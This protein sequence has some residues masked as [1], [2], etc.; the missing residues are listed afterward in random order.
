M[1]SLKNMTQKNFFII[2]VLLCSLSN[3]FNILTVSAAV[4]TLNSIKINEQLPPAGAIRLTV[5]GTYSDNTSS[6][7][8]SG[9]VWESSDINIAIVDS[10]GNVAFTGRAGAVTISATY[11][12]KNNSVSVTTQ[13]APALSAYIT[14]NGL[15]HSCERGV[16]YNLTI[17]AVYS[18]NS[19]EVM[20]NKY[21]TFTSSDTRIAVVNAEGTVSVHGEAG[22][23]MITAKYRDKT[24]VVISLIN[25]TGLV[26]TQ[27]IQEGVLSGI[28]ISGDMPKEPFQTRKLEVKGEYTDGYSRPLSIDAIWTTSNRE[29]VNITNDGIISFGGKYGEVTITARY[30]QYMDSVKIYIDNS[31]QVY[32]EVR[33]M[34]AAEALVHDRQKSY[35]DESV[36]DAGNIV[37]TLEKLVAAYQG[38]NIQAFKDIKN[39]WSEKEINIASELGII[40]GYSDNTFKP[41]ERISRAEFAAVIYKAFSVRYYIDDPDKTF[42]DVKGLWYQDYVMALKNSNIINGYADGTFKPNSYITRGEMIAIISRLIVKEDI[43]QKDSTEK[44]KDFNDSFW[45]KGDI[46]KLYSIGALEMI[47]KS[48][49]EPNKSAT[50]AEVVNII[51]RLLMNI[52]KNSK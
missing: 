25:S 45:A 10:N 22:A 39:H 46:D 49:L 4:P 42:K 5:T 43:T 37:T 16:V 19:V 32:E 13:Y 3:S 52:D 29:I 35:F 8:G 26:P 31:Q 50:R 11:E 48:K 51:V 15:P 7:I 36:V 47:G 24:A 30:G 17:Q 12:G 34:S 38:T 33:Q 21:V 20:N 44:Y 41:N 14:I 23:F 2:I 27:Y 40:S 9:I 1:Y 18:D 28:K 6:V